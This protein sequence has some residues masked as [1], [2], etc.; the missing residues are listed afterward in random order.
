MKTNEVD[1]GQDI[2][3]SRDIIARIDEL[4]SLLDEDFECPDCEQSEPISEWGEKETCPHCGEGQLIGL[5]DEK[6]ELEILKD[7]ASQC[8]Y[9]D[10]DFGTTLIRDSYFEQYAQELAE[11]IGAIDRNA[12]WPLNNIDWDT[13]ADELKIDYTCVNFDGEDYWLRA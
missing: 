8:N 3:D 1:N 11:D 7:L 10:W 13:A 6:D 9:G 4:Q 12:N 5:D 2:I